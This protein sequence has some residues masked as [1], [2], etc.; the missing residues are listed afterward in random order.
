MA[1]K[2][3]GQIAFELVFD[4]SK[5]M[6]R[7]NSFNSEI[8]EKF[9]KSFTEAGKSAK[10]A[11]ETSNAKI[12]EILDDTTRSEKAKAAKI[13]RIYRKQ[14]DS[15]SDAMS[16][17]W[18]HI[19][20]KSAKGSNTTKRH[21]SQ[22][23]KKSKRASAEIEKNFSNSF[24]ST[25]K[26]MAA[27]LTAALSVKKLVDFGKGCIELG[28]D[29]EEVQNVVDVT[30]PSM[31]AKVDLFA[32]NAAASFGL[33]E[34]MTKK[35]TGTFG[36][37]AKAFGFS[38]EQSYGMATALTGLAGDV[39]SFYNLSQ[40][41]AYTKLKSVFTGETESLKDLGVVMTQTALDSYAMANGFGKTTASMSEAEKVALRYSFVQNQLSTASGDFAR[42]SGS[43]ANQVKIL[44][45]Q[46][47]SLKASLGQGLI[48]LFKPVLQVI[49]QV[50][51]KLVTLAKA[52]KA[53]TELI[54]GKESSEVGN[55]ASESL[56]GATASAE[57][58]ES[59]TTSAGNAASKTTKKMRE[60]MGFDKV[61]KLSDSSE[62]SSSGSSGSVAGNAINFGTLVSGETVLDEVDCK[63]QRILN[64]CIELQKVFTQGFVITLGDA[65]AF[66]TIQESI[67]SIKRSFT[68]LFSN[69]ELKNT[70]DEWLDSVAYK[71]G[72][73][74]GSFESIGLT[75]ADHL[76]GGFSKYLENNKENIQVHLSN[77]LKTGTEL[78]EII[79]DSN[80]AIANIFSVLH[81]D[82]AKGILSNILQMFSDT[83]ITIN[84]IALN[85][86]RDLLKLITEPFVDNADGI[87]SALEN[88]LRP[89]S[90]VMDS[91]V[92]TWSK[93]CN[94]VRD[95]YDQNVKPLVDSFSDGVSKIVGILVENYNTYVV[96]VLDKLSGKFRD[97][98]EKHINPAIDNFR[99]AVG[100]V[101]DRLNAV[102]K[103]LLEPLF[104]WIAK[105]IMPILALI[106][107]LIGTIF[108][109]KL[110]ALADLIGSIFVDVGKLASGLEIL[111]HSIKKIPSK[112]K[113]TFTAMKDKTW[114]K[115]QKSWENLKNTTVV[116]TLSAKI[117][118][119]LTKFKKTWDSLQN[120]TLSIKADVSAA[121]TNIK[122]LINEKIIAKLNG[123]ID[124]L[125]KLPGVNVP[126][127]PK[128][129]QGGYVKR[130]APQLA[131]IG[132]NMRQGEIVAP[133][134][135]LLAMARQ[136]ATMSGG[137][138]NVEVVNLLRQILVLLQNLNLVASID[139]DE[140]KNLIVR[141]IN[142]DTKTNGVCE[143]IR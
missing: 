98:F 76:L 14:G 58:L 19:E 65:S 112:V 126:K 116:K 139:V 142:E 49:N 84:E 37:M 107:E 50:I 80:M 93:V 120:K 39:A 79:S 74:V 127:I 23:S 41:E 57:N 96:P 71:L 99:K 114:D 21:M 18:S 35:Y 103:E 118:S 95:I 77:V 138:N 110:A 140:L 30:F 75:L 102:W 46:F 135:K 36:A 108:L 56:E 33:S 92:A 105:N 63:F 10:K 26:K 121:I 2:D 60:L 16:K 117:S 25:A 128:L 134:G 136:A 13:A 106:I 61:S 115:I 91:L 132:D 8:K 104:A 9:T 82:A 55:V 66:Q 86:K 20:R 78:N 122:K 59:A 137:L 54:T 111:V 72:T 62:T 7:I 70:F 47:E 44:Q 45:L 24:A 131:I 119:T 31:S 90:K 40:D 141:L 69:S 97:V 15:M 32:Q 27:T 1:I 28:S 29:L 43:W 12:Q 42:T 52:F 34:T 81:S 6:E 133:E 89:C 38:E 4:G 113:T 68:E 64:R 73:M 48:N 5:M 109:D 83:F 11:V 125:N 100:H 51:A 53:L 101:V 129:A 85:F 17:A 3:G 143:I 123:A 88:T 22:M 67:V 124:I 87:K 130:N 94:S